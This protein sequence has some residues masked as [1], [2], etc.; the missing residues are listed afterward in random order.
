MDIN[1]PEAALWSENMRLKS[2]NAYMLETRQ[3]LVDEIERLRLLLVRYQAANY[4]PE[5][6]DLYAETQAA[7]T[8]TQ[9]GGN[10]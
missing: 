6:C 3:G 9:G 4:I 2:E 1:S 5:D 8:A 10:G 7:L